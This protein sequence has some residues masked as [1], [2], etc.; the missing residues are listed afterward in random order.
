MVSWLVLNSNTI[1][2][3]LT[4]HRTITQWGYL[5]CSISSRCCCSLEVFYIV[6]HCLLYYDALFHVS[7]TKQIN[8]DYNMLVYVIHIWITGLFL[9]IHILQWLL[10]IQRCLAHVL[11]PCNIV[12]GRWKGK[13]HSIWPFSLSSN[14]SSIDNGNSIPPVCVFWILNV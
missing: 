2:L 5:F 3:Y 9:N 7:K 11:T 6:F 10:G 1:I 14:S 13:V 8:Y 12:T 4:P